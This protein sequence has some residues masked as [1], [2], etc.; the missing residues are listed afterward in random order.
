[1]GDVLNEAHQ[2]SRVHCRKVG[3]TRCGV[4]G[5][6]DRSVLLSRPHNTRP[7]D[8]RRP[9]AFNYSRQPQLN[10]PFADWSAC[11][12]CKL[13]D[14]GHNKCQW[15]ILVTHHWA[16]SASGIPR[17][18]MT[19]PITPPGACHSQRV[20]RASLTSLTCAHALASS[21]SFMSSPRSIM[22]V[23]SL[24]TTCK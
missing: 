21:Q 16:L 2:D 7:Q 3:P 22:R 12:M 23:P 20:R 15:Q 19:L 14:S 17:M 11:R 24:V 5:T 6:Q 9:V 4:P 13:D 1:M 8:R 10:V 18:L